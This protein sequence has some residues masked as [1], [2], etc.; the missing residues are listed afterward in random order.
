ME[1][2]QV[3]EETDCLKFHMSGD[4]MNFRELLNDFDE[5]ALQ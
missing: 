3:D 5:L 4:L 1:L 2:E